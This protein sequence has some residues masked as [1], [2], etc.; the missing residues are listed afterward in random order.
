M[1]PLVAW[2][3]RFEI[4]EARLP[5]EIAHLD[6]ICCDTCERVIS[7]IGIELDNCTFNS[8]ELQAL[9][10]RAPLGGLRMNGID[11]KVCRRL[12]QVKFNKALMAAIWVTDPTD[13]TRLR[14]SNTDP[15]T[16]DLSAAQV[17]AIVRDRLAAKKVGQRLSVAAALQ[18]Q[19]ETARGMLNAKS[20]AARRRGAKLL[21]ITVDLEADARPLS[22]RKASSKRSL[23]SAEIKAQEI[24][25]FE[26]ER[27]DSMRAPADQ[28]R[29][30][31][32]Y[33][34]ISS[35]ASA[36]KRRGL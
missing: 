28:V 30:I 6:V 12:F 26:L 10:R 18:R 25:A 14:V 13:G 4:H 17:A 9:R 16:A 2:N 33:A 32:K 36:S 22:I 34:V 20:M 21:G 5:L 8:S 23:P 3:N 11:E 35:P 31:P 24:H 27:A 29:S 15:L 19:R 1:S 7:H